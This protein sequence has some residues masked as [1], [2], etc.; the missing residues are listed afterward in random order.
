MVEMLS[1]VGEV[2]VSGLPKLNDYSS[3]NKKAIF[4]KFSPLLCTSNVELSV[5]Q[6][7]MPRYASSRTNNVLILISSSS[8]DVTVPRWGGNGSEFESTGQHLTYDSHGSSAR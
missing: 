2:P 1:I 7:P 6:V 4:S 3:T 5:I 8:L